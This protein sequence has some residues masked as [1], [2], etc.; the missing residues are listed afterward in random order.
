MLRTS[1]SEVHQIAVLAIGED[2]VGVPKSALVRL[3][4]LSVLLPYTEEPAWLLG[5]ALVDYDWSPIICLE[6]WLRGTTSVLPPTTKLALLD[7]G[8]G[9]PIGLVVDDVIGFR[10]VSQNEIAG[11]R[12]PIEESILGPVWAITRDNLQLVDVAYLFSHP[13]LSPQ[14]MQ[15]Y[16]LS[17]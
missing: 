12:R 13:A 8:A 2:T 15:N 6:T 17:G 16:Y 14:A 3:A 11:D 9:Y 4:R 7:H 10:D 5:I 1:S